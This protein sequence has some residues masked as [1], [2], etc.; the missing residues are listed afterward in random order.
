[1]ILL[2]ACAFRGVELEHAEVAEL[3][4]VRVQGDG[5]LFVALDNAWGE[6]IW[7]V[8]TGYSDTT[9]DQAWVEGLGVSHRAT[10][11]A[12]RGLGMVRLR[13][14]ELPPFT[15]GG[16]QVLALPCAVRDLAATSSVPEGVAGVLGTNLLRE[17]VVEIDRTDGVIRLHDPAL[18][19]GE[20]DF[21]LRREAGTPR[22]RA[23][24]TLDG[25]TTWPVIDTG[26]S[27]SWLQTGRMDL[28]EL[29]PRELMVS[30]TGSSGPR[31][32]TTRVFE[33]SAA[34]LGGLDSGPIE[35]YR[36]ESVL[37][38]PLVGMDLIGR[39][40][41]VLDYPNRAAAVTLSDPARLRRVRPAD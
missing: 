11:Y 35:V 12:S 14:A 17:F 41:L 6:T 38:D 26:A 25:H 3:E 19:R 32:Q 33:A 15:L 4:L 10:L 5:R 27:S 16:H 2:L 24:V 9:C 30:G 18:W 7:F 23:P 39:Y 28:T 21:Q 20:T 8:D 37:R 13:K 34:M 22:L 29:E 36:R 1:M 40:D 31:V